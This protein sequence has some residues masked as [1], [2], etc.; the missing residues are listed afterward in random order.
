VVRNTIVA[1]HGGYGIVI[2]TVAYHGGFSIIIIITVACAMTR[3]LA[4]R[5]IIIITFAQHGGCCI[6]TITTAQHGVHNMVSSITTKQDGLQECLDGTQMS[7]NICAAR[8]LVVAHE[9]TT[10]KSATSLPPPA[11]CHQPEP[12]ATAWRHQLQRA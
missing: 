11:C 5:S 12:G 10:S 6:I 4:G 8:D 1:Q 2:L 7:G 9:A 3:G